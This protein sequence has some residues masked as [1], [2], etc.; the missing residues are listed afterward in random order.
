M[1]YMD[2]Q[3][4]RKEEPKSNIDLKAITLIFPISQLG[5]KLFWFGTKFSKVPTKHFLIFLNDA[6]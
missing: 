6:E 2:I 3:V 5:Q 1:C 4:R